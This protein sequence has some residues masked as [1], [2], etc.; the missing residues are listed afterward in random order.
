MKSAPIPTRIDSFKGRWATLSN[1]SGAIINFEGKEYP[2]VEH[3][4]Q[5]AK[6]LNPKKREPFTFPIP[7]GHAKRI[8]RELELRPD[9]EEVK[10]EIMKRLLLQ[11][12][13]QSLN[14][15]ILI[16]TFKAELIEG[17]WW[18]DIFWGVCDGS[19]RHFKCPGHAPYGENHLGKLLMEV[20]EHYTSIEV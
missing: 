5:A 9:W 12:F 2:S 19:G 8:G 14:K 16:S 1:F 18:H 11:K 20:R 6:T 10:L 4:F 15:R 17:N 13:G 3:A 7:P